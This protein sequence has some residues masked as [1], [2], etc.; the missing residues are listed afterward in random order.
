MGIKLQS[1]LTIEEQKVLQLHAAWLLA[2]KHT[3][4]RFR[5][6]KGG[7][8]SAALCGK[9]TLNLWAEDAKAHVK[10]IQR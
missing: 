8:A 2:G 6:Q 9:S 1:L 10:K 7:E 3:R 5:A 4:A